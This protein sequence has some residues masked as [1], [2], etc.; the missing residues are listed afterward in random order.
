MKT[1]WWYLR[2][3]FGETAYEHYLQHR[4]PAVP[5]L[6]RREFERRRADQHVRCCC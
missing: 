4:D 2:E 1:L 3:L 6:T 5:V